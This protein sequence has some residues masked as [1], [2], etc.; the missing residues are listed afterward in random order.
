MLLLCRHAA[1]E[2]GLGAVEFLEQQ[3][4][5]LPAQHAGEWSA[6]HAAV[7]KA[8]VDVVSFLIQRKG[9]MNLGP[10]EAGWTPLHA[11]CACGSLSMVQM[12]L[13]FGADSNAVDER[14]GGK[15]ETN[16]SP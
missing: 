5:A 16:P 9:Y 3:G 14:V 7:V 8:D 13:Q 11:A 1:V 15:H 12:L 6:L 2:G 10:A 4:T